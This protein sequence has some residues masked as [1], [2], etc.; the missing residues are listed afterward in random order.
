MI[1]IN[2]LLESLI[3]NCQFTVTTK[4]LKNKWIKQTIS[5]KIDSILLKCNYSKEK[6]HRTYFT[7]QNALR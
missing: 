7:F 1:S 5:R 2:L 4:T 3:C 6:F